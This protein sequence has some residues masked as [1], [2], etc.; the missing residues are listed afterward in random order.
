[1]AEKFNYPEEDYDD[2]FTVLKGLSDNNFGTIIRLL[3][4][5]GSAMSGY[6]M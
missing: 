4:D 5:G 2:A 6:V 1:M 3:T